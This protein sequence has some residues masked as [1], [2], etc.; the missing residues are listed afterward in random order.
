MLKNSLGFLKEIDL[1][2]LLNVINSRIE[3]LIDKDHQI[4]HSYFMSIAT[5]NDL[6]VAFKNK[7][8]PLLQ[9]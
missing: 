9:E 3:K 5:I 7:I 4:G 2:D 6:K 1:P 8:I